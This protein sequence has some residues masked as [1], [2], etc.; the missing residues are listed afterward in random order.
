MASTDARP[1]PLQNTA[2]RLY[3]ELR[4]SDNNPV[5]D[6]TGV[7]SERSLDG[8]AFADCTNEATHV[9]NG[10]GYLDLT[11]T[12]MNTDETTVV[13]KLAGAIQ[14]S[15]FIYPAVTNDIPVNLVNIAGSAVSTSTAQLG[16]NA[17]Q[18]GG[19]A[20]GSGAITAGSI[21][22]SAI[23]NAKFAAG[24]IDAAAIADNAIDAGA[25]AAS[26]I[27]AGKFASGAITSTVMATDCI[28]SSQLAGSAVT[29]IQS[30][31]ATAAAL[32]TVDTEVG[33]ILVDT[34]TTLPAQIAALNNL[35]AAQVNAEVVD[36]LT[37]DTF[38]QPGQATPAATTTLQLML[39]YIYKNWRNVKEQTDEQ[40][41]LMNDDG[42]TVDQKAPVSDD[43]T[44]ATKGE[45]V[46]GP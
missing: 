11:T 31:L 21:A 23:T 44:T 20:W 5:T 43:G 3:L 32:A 36:V 7:D 28:T 12:E 40:W 8:A 14:F 16:V 6:W 18:A 13:V 26:A 17:V 29:E 30:G 2:Y 19:T 35:S 33:D 24:A 45:I 15:A 25:I 22:S 4:D 41:S 9:G 42:T 37:V 34:G 38:A 46:T 39:G 1:I 27:T 10:C